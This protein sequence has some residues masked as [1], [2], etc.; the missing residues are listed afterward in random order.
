MLLG[1]PRKVLNI[2]F[3][4]TSYYSKNTWKWYHEYNDE[5]RKISST[6]LMILGSKYFIFHVAVVI[7]MQLFSKLSTSS[8]K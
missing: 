4:A 2:N 3:K 6:A 1:K 8:S 5:M 7:Y